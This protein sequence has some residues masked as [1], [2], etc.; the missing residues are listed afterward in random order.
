LMGDA[1]P[2]GPA[3]LDRERYRP[4]EWTDDPE[5]CRQAGIPQDRHVATTPR[6]AQQMWGR[7]FAAG[8]P[9]QWVTADSVYGD[10]R[11][12]RQWWE[13]HPHAYVL[14]VT[15]QE[16]V[17]RGG[18]QRQVK[19]LLAA[20]PEDGWTR[21]SAGDGA[22][23]PRWYDWRW[24]PLPPRWNPAGAAGCWSGGV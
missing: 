19:T 6:L 21:R 9:A 13:A 14:A 24:L 4:T 8:V 3:L 1:S 5:R 20:L 23:G 12:W 7:A 11:R 17:G 16:Y 10:D 15:G 22:Q 18:Q 2:L